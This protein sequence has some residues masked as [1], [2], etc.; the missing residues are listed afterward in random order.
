MDQ[1]ALHS[2]ASTATP[3]DLPG[4]HDVHA[5]LPRPMPP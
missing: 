5:E 1:T 3:N 2:A 4:G